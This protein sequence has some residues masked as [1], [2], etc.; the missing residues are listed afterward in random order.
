MSEF[1]ALDE[2]LVSEGTEAEENVV[3][4]PLPNTVDVV[5]S[6]L[7]APDDITPT[8][9]SFN[10]F[11]DGDLLLAHNRRRQVEVPGGHRDPLREGGREHPAVAATRESFEETG[12]V[13]SDLKPVGFMRSH[14]DGVRPEE[15]KYPWP[16]SCQ[17]FFAALIDRVV[18]F[19]E[20]DECRPPV[21]LTHEQA[22]QVFN[23]RTLALYRAA[24]QLM[25]PQP[26]EHPVPG[27]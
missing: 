6:D 23:G 5:L 7:L 9:F 11:D 21:R 3:Y 1:M 24:R 4:I 26:V 13:V 16:N 17:Q 15:Y 19:E 20:T 12:A 22:E 2:M 25:F 27:P 8:G 14:S 10:F 18:D